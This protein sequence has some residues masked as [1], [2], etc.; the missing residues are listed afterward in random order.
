M[1]QDIDLPSA[2][3]PSAIARLVDSG[4]VE[5]A[6]Q[7]ARDMT[8]QSPADGGAWRVLGYTLLS[9]SNYADA[10]AALQ[11]ALELD[12]QDAAALEYLGWLHRRAGDL[13]AAIK[14]LRAS[15][16][17]DKARARA[18]IMLADIYRDRK[19]RRS[20][21]SH[22]EYAL[23]WAPDHVHAHTSLGELLAEARRLQEAALHRARAAELSPTLTN[24]VH[25]C[26]AA[27]KICD[28]VAVE[29]LEQIVVDKLRN[30][31]QRSDYPQPFPV[32]AM[33]TAKPRDILA[34][35]AQVASH[36]VARPAQ[37]HRAA[38]ELGA[39]KRLRIGYLSPDMHT[40]PMVHLSTELFELHDRSR[41]EIILF[42]YAPPNKDSIYRQRALAAFDKVIDIRELSDSEAAKAMADEG[43]AIAA[44]IA[45]WTTGNRAQILAQRP[46]PVT[47]QWMGFP[48]TMGAPWIDYAVVDWILA[49]PGS[50]AEFSEKL[51]RLPFTYQSN[52]RKRR[53][54]EKITRAQA[55]LPEDAFVFCNF[56][57][58]FKFNRQIFGLWMDLLR[59]RPNAILWLMQE[60]E[61]ATVALRQ[62]AQSFGI[63]E[64]R[65]I[66]APRLPLDQHLARIALAD[67]A[68]DCAP[69]GSH[70]T[71][72][73]ALWAGV[74]QLALRGDTFAARV[75]ASLLTAIGLPELISGTPES[76][77]D[78]ALRL[79]ADPALLA[80][81]RA[82]LA[83]NRL[84]TPLF[85][86]AAFTRYM[87][88]GYEA[89]W[90]RCLDGLPPDHISVPATL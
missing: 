29:R 90:R 26:H 10:E 11:K 83:A 68:L 30:D 34:A 49:P 81:Y 74:P 5:E 85:D 6:E 17:I 88:A 51:I 39:E 76:H 55:G 41:F 35:G 28:W 33:P 20:A 82:R 12:P 54:G 67:L 60:N 4:R 18:W 52:D 73:D 78:L 15:V 57:Q 1:E 86:S 84:T 43:I 46:A 3:A 38:V 48:G 22:Y 32:L 19:K 47:L 24:Q 8:R 89:I 64:D 59:Q 70:T 65:V 80:S 63:A 50:E 53:I 45:G 2:S 13:D 21:I 9:R 66:F 31:P 72:S 79:S 37:P 16:A 56:N 25:A 7:Q 14:A 36:Y 44:D 58:S 61:W 23:Y 77:R 69:Y 71:A 87:E 42:D 40:H 75:S 27:R 62:H